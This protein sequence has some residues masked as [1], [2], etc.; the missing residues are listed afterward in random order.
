MLEE[1]GQIGR[2][3]DL[4]SSANIPPAEAYQDNVVNL[5]DKH[6]ETVQA[7]LTLPKPYAT[8]EVM[9]ACSRAGFVAVVWER[10][11]EWTLAFAGWEAPYGWFRYTMSVQAGGSTFMFLWG[12]ILA[13]LPLI[14]FGV[15]A[16]LY[17][18][19][20]CSDQFL[21]ADE[22]RVFSFVNLLTNGKGGVRDGDDE[23]GPPQ[24]DARAPDVLTPRDG[25]VP[26]QEQAAPLA[27][28]A[29]A[30]EAGTSYTEGAPEARP[31]PGLAPS[32]VPGAEAGPSY[33]AL[34]HHLSIHG[35]QATLL[36]CALSITSTRFS[37]TLTTT[38]TSGTLAVA[39]VK[40]PREG[41][42]G[43]RGTFRHRIQAT[44]SVAY[45]LATGTTAVA[46][47]EDAS[48]LP[49]HDVPE[50]PPAP[51]ITASLE[52]SREGAGGALQPSP[53]Q[54]LENT[55]EEEEEKKVGGS[56]PGEKDT[57]GEG[58]EKAGGS[59]HALIQRVPTQRDEGENPA[60]LSST[61]PLASGPRTALPPAAAIALLPKELSE[62][63][64]LA[65]N[66]VNKIGN[67][68]SPSARRPPSR[69]GWTDSP[70]SIPGEAVRPEA[71]LTVSQAGPSGPEAGRN[72][73]QAGPSEEG[74]VIDYGLSMCGEG[75]GVDAEGGIYQANA[76]RLFETTGWFDTVTMEKVEEEAECE[77]CPKQKISNPQPLTRNPKPKT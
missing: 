57:S 60:R 13:I 74:V 40:S 8:G 65:A 49:P 50:T 9:C 22:D 6:C 44:A 47:R 51:A 69:G 28:G 56:I 4:S 1:D 11:P 75:E 41:P 77:V 20:S 66:P 19:F 27:V 12:L 43:D 7:V 38:A 39:L 58:A 36:T 45:R 32:S 53:A 46:S 21:V 29:S 25:P 54:A 55:T 72:A 42:T 26:A 70:L 61:P 16:R 23:W 14:F 24:S 63:E 76:M 17:L 3:A 18:A 30:P 73:S 2:R 33:N 64:E 68:L 15:S 37:G 10:P 5:S 34:A 71:G 62:I 35:W 67:P 59:I 48:S 31:S 52:G